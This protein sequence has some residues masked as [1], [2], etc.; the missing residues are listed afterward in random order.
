MKVY[1]QIGTNNGNDRFRKKV[2]SEKPDIVILVE[3]NSD[4]IDTIKNNYKD[5]SN[6][7]VYN[8]AIYYSSNQEV[9]LGI[10]AKGG[11]IGSKADNGHHYGDAHFSLLPMNDWGKREDMAW[12]KAK[13]ITFDDICKNHNINE[14]EYLQIDTE[15]FDSEIIKMLN[16]DEYKINNIRFEIWSFDETCFKD[17]NPDKWKE[18]G[19]A[20]MTMVYEKLTKY[21]YTFSKIN[22]E[23][24]DDILATLCV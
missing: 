17:Y 18:L 9:E 1:F 22:D 7:Y 5:I 11:V 14:I 6:V 3:P 24:G 19:K 15:G 16:L 2:I 20:G 8:N 4:L 13:T 12:I 10:P 21:R 23:D